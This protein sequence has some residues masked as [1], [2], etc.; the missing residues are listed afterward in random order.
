VPDLAAVPREWCSLLGGDHEAVA[1][2]L[3]PTRR[4]AGAVK[5]T[6]PGRTCIHEIRKFKGEYL[7]VC[8]DGCDT[9]TLP[10]DEVVVHRLDVKTFAGEIAGALGLETVPAEALPQL[11]GVWR[12]GDYVPLAGFRFP[13][14]LAFTGE[15]D[16]MRR[17]VDGLAAR[18]EPFVLAA[19][20][21]SA[22]NQATADLVKRGKSCFLA[23][24]EL[25][26]HGD[27]RLR[28]LDGHTSDSIFAELRA[29]NVPQPKPDDG[30]VM[31]PTPAGARWEDVSIRF[32]DGET[33]SVRV[34]DES[35]VLLYSQMGMIDGRSKKPTKQWELLRD[36]VD[37]HGI[38]D[39][40]SR[41]AGRE[42]QKRR[43]MLAKD[44]RRFFR[45][46][47]DPFRA[48]GNGWR[49][50]FAVDDGL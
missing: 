6:S 17:A 40:G 43:E 3:L 7:S 19:P 26:G 42:K 16:A 32:N 39:W 41:K 46:D 27:G 45:I 1:R 9:V 14:C 8:P 4:I 21:R 34:K 5:S 33:V 49:A 28:L 13:V 10:R 18:G 22:V 2:F 23:L 50:R 31:F 35:A 38:I 47:G 25:I 48:E 24:H 29:A 15:P 30:M 11:A 20:S 44:L 36:F 12:I 37:E